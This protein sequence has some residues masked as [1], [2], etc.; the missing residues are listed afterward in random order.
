MKVKELV[1]SLL[2]LDQEKEINFT[3]GADSGR[4]YWFGHSGDL[5]DFEM[6]DGQV[7]FRLDFDE[8]NCDS[9]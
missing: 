9:Q 3:F 6:E 1:E 7:V 4:S 8:D 5:M 2:M